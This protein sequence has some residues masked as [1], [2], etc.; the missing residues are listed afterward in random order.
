[1]KLLLNYGLKSKQ[2]ESEYECWPQL[3]QPL[4]NSN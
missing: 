4:I 1:M 3:L 2:N